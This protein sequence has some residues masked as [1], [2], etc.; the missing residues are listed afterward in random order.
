[1]EYRGVEFNVVQT[2]SPKGWRWVVKVS[3]SERT[4]RVRDRHTA[5]RRAKE[6]IDGLIEKQGPA[7]E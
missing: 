3:Q 6:V 2:L 4:G 1:M 5:V 7:G